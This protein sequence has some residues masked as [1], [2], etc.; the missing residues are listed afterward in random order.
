MIPSRRNFYQALLTEFGAV[1]GKRYQI[2]DDNPLLVGHDGDRKG[3]LMHYFG[4][5]ERRK[6][7]LAIISRRLLSLSRRRGYRPDQG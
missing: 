7:K 5:R 1:S 2:S 3:S 4:A 6:I